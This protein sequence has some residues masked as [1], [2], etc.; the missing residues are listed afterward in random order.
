VSRAAIA[1]WVAIVGLSLGTAGPARAADAKDAKAAKLACVQASDKAQTLKGDGKLIDAREQLLACAREACP[2]PVRKDCTRRLAELEDALP[3]IVIGA[4]DSS[5]KDVIDVKVSIDG[6]VVLEKLDG[7]AISVDP[8]AH[9]FKFEHATLPAV[10]EQVL[11]QQGVKN[12][13]FTVSFPAPAPPPHS[14]PPKPRIPLGTWIL[15][16]VGVVAIGGFAVLG[17]GA[18]SRAN[19]LRSTCAPTCASEDVDGLRRRMLFADV[20]LGVGVLALGGA[21][22]VWGLSSRGAEPSP[23]ALVVSITP[24]AGGGAIGLSGVFR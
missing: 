24:L 15:G 9:T 23:S 1:P 3:S 6:V 18:R 22:L 19:E 20:A 7:K 14:D 8:G 21:T 17:L 10:T 16:G 2:A 12:R 13:P 11:V 4:K 5:G